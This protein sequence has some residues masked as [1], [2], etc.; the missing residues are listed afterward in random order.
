[1][2]MEHLTAMEK[3]SLLEAAEIADGLIQYVSAPK[4]GGDL[5]G[6]HKRHENAAGK[7]LCGMCSWK[8]KNKWEC[9]W[10]RSGPCPKEKPECVGFVQRRSTSHPPQ[11]KKKALPV[12]EGVKFLYVGRPTWLSASRLAPDGSEGARNH[13]GVVTVAYCTYDTHIAYVAFSFCSPK[14][15]W[16]RAMGR[17][18]ALARLRTSYLTVPYFYDAKRTV[19][20]V[21]RAVLSHDWKTLFNVANYVPSDL[22]HFQ[23]SVPG[24]TRALAKR[25]WTTKRPRPRIAFISTPMQLKDLFSKYCIEESVEISGEPCKRPNINKPTAQQIIARIMRDIAALGND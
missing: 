10:R 3:R 17:D 15:S 22:Q 11:P 8:V 9:S 20:E 25:I 6:V 1:M 24:W 21:V 5:P 7:K 2:Q 16:C 14:D 23:C 12:P 18:M 4:V 19:R 13:E